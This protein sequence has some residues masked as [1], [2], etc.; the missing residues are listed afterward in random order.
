MGKRVSEGV[1]V[2]GHLYLE[3]DALIKKIKRCKKAVQKSY[4]DFYD[5]RI[6]EWLGDG[7][8][9]DI[10]DEKRIKKECAANIGHAIDGIIQTLEVIGIE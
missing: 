2:D 3:R 4:A 7:M 1:V 6:Q 8:E 5:A 10:R 9:I